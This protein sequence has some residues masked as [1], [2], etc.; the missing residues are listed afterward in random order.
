VNKNTGPITYKKISQIISEKKSVSEF[1]RVKVFNFSR[2]A[3]END[4]SASFVK[5]ASLM[6]I[7]KRGLEAALNDKPENILFSIPVSGT[8]ELVLELTR[9]IPEAE[10]FILTTKD[11]VSDKRVSYNPG[12]HY[13]GI[14]KGKGNSVA[15]VSIFK[16]FVMGIISDE[17]GNYVLGS[18]KNSDNSYSG[19]YILYN[20]ADL[21]VKDKFKCGVEDY[22]DIFTRAIDETKNK[23]T[24][25]EHSDNPARLPVKVYFEADYKLY[26][27]AGNNIDTVAN[28]ISGM[29]NAVKTIYQNE[30]I[31]F[32]ISQIG[33]WTVPDP[34]RNM[35]DSYN[36]LL[37]FG[38][39]SKDDFQGNLA[40]FLSTRNAGLGGIA[41]IRVMCS[42]YNVQDSSGRFAYCNIEPN[43]NNYPAYSWTVNVVTHE[44]GHSLGSR[45]THAC[46]WPAGPGGA[47]RAIDSCYTNE[48]CS[49]PTRPRVGTIMS[50]CHLWPVSQGGGVNLASGFGRLPGDT[51]RLRY[52]QAGCLDRVLNS[53][54]RP[55]TFDLAQNFPNPYNPTTVIRFALPNE[56]VVSLKVYD[57]NGRFVADLLQNKFYSAG[58]YDYEFNSSRYGLS[59]GIYFYQITADSYG[60]TAKFTETKRMVLIK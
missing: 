16:N 19:Q 11:G 31:P 42:E 20:D 47:I 48:N 38:V 7:S 17:T 40:V 2:K 29:F 8:E 5:N 14:I 55:S 13:S 56:S 41:W 53:S 9:S 21:L 18:V 30:G 36:I 43:Y 27:D 58:F 3:N 6:I 35:N 10:D 26:T 1:K 23:F 50:Y 24:V 28:F 54:E 39:A 46:W 51:I 45:H 59:S 37:K 22:E 25:D 15:S 60:G 34:Y 12:L 4:H 32:V 49:F 44:M 52:S 33:V 57:V